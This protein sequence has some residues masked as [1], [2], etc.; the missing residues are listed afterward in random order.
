MSIKNKKLLSKS[1]EWIR[2]MN[3]K[4]L[5]ELCIEGMN[6]FK[7]LLGSGFRSSKK[8]GWDGEKFNVYNEIDDSEQDLTLKQIMSPQHTNIGEAIKEKAF[9]GNTTYWNPS[10]GTDNTKRPW[11]HRGSNPPMGNVPMPSGLIKAGFNK[12]MMPR[13]GMPTPGPW[14]VEEMGDHVWIMDRD[15][16][17]LAEIISHDEE[18]HSVPKSEQRANAALMAGAPRFVKE[19][20]SN[21]EYFAG[22]RMLAGEIR[23]MNPPG[24]PILDGNQIMGILGEKYDYLWS[25]WKDESE[26]EDF[27]EYV[28]TMKKYLAEG[29]GGRLIQFNKTDFSARFMTPWNYLYEIFIDRDQPSLVLLSP[30]GPTKTSRPNPIS[31]PTPGELYSGIKEKGLVHHARAAY[32]EGKELM[33]GRQGNPAGGFDVDAWWSGG[34]KDTGE[35]EVRAITKAGQR[36]LDLAGYGQTISVTL[37]RMEAMAMLVDMK[38]QKLRVDYDL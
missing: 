12:K 17:Y 11:W 5:K 1:G 26:Y 32:R 15:G 30:E 33:M 14:R 18:G 24:Q 36:Y 7:I 37:P 28:D 23:E 13:I 10:G 20:M 6:E 31:I 38:K 8:I 19:I 9:W 34:D 27:Q 22:K 29:F 21:L 3:A 35:I 4:H 25:R 2:V 16:N